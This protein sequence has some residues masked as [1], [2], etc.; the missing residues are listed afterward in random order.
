MDIQRWRQ[1]LEELPLGELY[2]YQEVGSTNS[3]AEKLVGQGAPPFSLVL[4]DAQT[5]GRGR[6][7]RGWITQPGSAL[8]LSWIL[9]PEPGRI[10]PELLGRLAGLG[11]VAVW[12]V[13][14][15]I[16]HLSANIKW[17]N[18]L[19]VEGKKVAGILPE[20]HW[21]GCQLTDIILGIGL[22]VHREA[23]PPD[24]ELLFPAATL[25]E[26]LGK[27]ISRLD[28]LIQIMES[29][30]KW[31]QRLAEPSLVNTWNS[32]LAY[33]DQEVVLSAPR[34]EIARGKVLGVDED[35]SLSLRDHSGLVQ[36]Y[37]SGEI[38]VRLV[39]RS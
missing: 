23:L 24:A 17:P 19:L 39:D 16:Y 30:L 4:A 34:G 37:H 10:Q 6:Q 36:S 15:E 21:D 7:G 20:V 26:C 35:G 5:A 28:L 32:A 12:E 14:Q 25:E 22:N 13:L 29:L 27:R 3:E 8:A 1:R 33:R 2:L 9:Y 31:Y 38:Q 11:A 18:D